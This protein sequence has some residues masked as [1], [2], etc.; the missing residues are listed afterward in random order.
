MVIGSLIQIIL[1]RDDW[2]GDAYTKDNSRLKLILTNEWSI[3][4][5]KQVRKR[6]A[7]RLYD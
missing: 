6:Q 4:P 2:L 7:K 3:A 1:I 5:P